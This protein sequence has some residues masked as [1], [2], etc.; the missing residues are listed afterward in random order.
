MLENQQPGDGGSSGLHEKASSQV[1]FHLRNK[2]NEL[3]VSNLAKGNTQ[4]EK[5]DENVCIE[6]DG[7]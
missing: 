5:P 1:L 4:M 7:M 2:A 6:K 3:G